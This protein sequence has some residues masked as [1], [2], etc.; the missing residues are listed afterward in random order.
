MLI[1]I[2]VLLKG[3][4]N[5]YQ[6]QEIP[7]YPHLSGC[8]GAPEREPSSPVL[9]ILSPKWVAQNHVMG[10]SVLGFSQSG[11]LPG[12]KG[13]SSC[14]GLTGVLQKCIETE[15]GK[16]FTLREFEIEGNHRKSKNWKLSV[17]CG[18]WPLQHLIQVFQ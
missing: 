15:D 17:R 14:L 4:G 1:I 9:L 10:G 8:C 3:Q 6:W 11:A 13:S 12:N 5:V 2:I 16:Q 18:G 7:F